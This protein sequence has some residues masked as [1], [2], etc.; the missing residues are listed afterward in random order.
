[1]TNNTWS[2]LSFYFLILNCFLFY[3]SCS[4]SLPVICLGVNHIWMRHFR[5]Q[6]CLSVVIYISFFFFLLY[7]SSHTRQQFPGLRSGAAPQCQRH[8]AHRRHQEAESV[9]SLRQGWQLL[10]GNM[11]FDFYA[12]SHMHDVFTILVT[13]RGWNKHMLLV[14]HRHTSQALC[15]CVFLVTGYFG[16]GTFCSDPCSLCYL[17]YSSHQQTDLATQQSRK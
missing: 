14:P 11:T 5:S 12:H 7:C 3:F 13:H 15:Y 6:F 9:A 4:F 10:E 2:H 16:K 1:M 17:C 8:Q